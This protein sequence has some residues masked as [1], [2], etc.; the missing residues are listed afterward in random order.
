MVEICSQL[1]SWFSSRRLDG[2][3]IP[4][5]SSPGR[6]GLSF[7]PRLGV[8]WASLVVLPEALSQA[9]TLYH[10]YT[11]DLAPGP[12]AIGSGLWVKG[13]GLGPSAAWEVKVI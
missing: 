1:S 3:G 6:E 2:C 8:S 5:G 4:P 11:T 13:C 9:L 12:P 10:R 7:L